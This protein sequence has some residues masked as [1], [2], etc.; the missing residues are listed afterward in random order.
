MPARY[1]LER[2]DWAN[3]AA[4]PMT[5]TH[6]PWRD[7]LI[8]FT[9]GLGMARTGNLAGAKRRDRSDEGFAHDPAARRPVLLGRPHR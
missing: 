6:I 3:A 9:R 2:A 8:R 4:L 5:P 1:V 7:S